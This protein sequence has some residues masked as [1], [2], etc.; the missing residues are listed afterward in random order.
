MPIL[1]PDTRTILEECIEHAIR[2]RLDYTGC[3]GRAL[4]ILAAV[5]PAAPPII[6]W[7]LAEDAMIET[8]GRSASERFAAEATRH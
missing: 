3:L 6:A 4:H 2:V 1:S 5:E 7:Q 8:L